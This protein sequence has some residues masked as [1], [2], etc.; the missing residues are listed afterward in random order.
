MDKLNARPPEFSPEGTVANDIVS[1]D[2]S[3]INAQPV[4][5]DDEILSD[6]LDGQ[7]SVTGKDTDDDPSQVYPKSDDVRQALRRCHFSNTHVSS[8]NEECIRKRMNQIRAFVEME[9]SIKLR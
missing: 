8:D 4:I 2:Y 7:V 1:A 3:V 6:V 9:I 5:T